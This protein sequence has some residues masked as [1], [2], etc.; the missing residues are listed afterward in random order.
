M[1]LRDGTPFWPLKN[2]L[3]G[4]YPPLSSDIRAE[5]AVIGGG[6]TGALLADS[7][8]AAGLGVALLDAREV[9]FGS[10]AASTALLQFEIDTNLHELRDM[11]GR[12]Q[13]DRAYTLC[14][15]AIA[16]VRDM[17]HELEDGEHP[18]GYTENGSLYFASRR[19][20]VAMLEREQRARQEAGLPSE[21][22]SGREVSRRFG[23]SAPAALF[24]P[25]GAEVDPYRLAHRLLAR[26]E[27][28]G[29]AIYDRTEVTRLEHGNAG[30]TLHTDRG[31]KVQADWVIVACGY[32]AGRFLG[33]Q[34]AA[35]KNSYALA[36]EPLP[37]GAEPWPGSCLLW[38]TARPYIYARL[39][40]ERRIVIGGED[41]PFHSPARRERRLKAKAQRLHKRL[42]RMF[43]ALN[44]EVAY[45][46]AGTF[47]ETADGLAY[48]GPDPGA[49]PRVLYALGYGG[50]GITYSVQAA[51]LL[52]AH[53]HGADAQ[54]RA[55]LALFSLGR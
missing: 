55:D 35:L 33:R 12:E 41:D 44:T 27:R 39:T 22:L 36:T 5:V 10:T 20:D 25:L 17:A 50:N 14:A 26:A 4:L 40:P 49:N 51:R 8:S 9:G 47:G 38:E 23:F 46:W 29:A 31:A 1:D 21:H 15:E 11:M 3:L 28:R 6:I 13:A 16:R 43:P 45:A 52:A 24:S 2:G 18:C 42:S 30:L 37:D 34:P 32:E 54:E 7:L 48:L 53:I 19:R